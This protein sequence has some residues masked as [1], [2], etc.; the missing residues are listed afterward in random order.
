MCVALVGAARAQVTVGNAIVATGL[1]DGVTTAF[2]LSGQGFGSGAVGSAVSTW[3]FYTGD[4]SGTLAITPLLFEYSGTGFD[5]VLRAIGTTVVNVTAGAHVDLPFD[6]A[7]GSATITS[8]DFY[9]GWKDDGGAV[10]DLVY[11]GT[12]TLAF[13][14]NASPSLVLG[15]TY[16][17]D[18][19]L[20]L[21]TYSISAT[22]GAVP[23]PASWAAL[24]GLVAAIGSAW[25][26]GNR[27]VVF[28][29]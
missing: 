7:S 2:I 3:S 27:R 29:R 6:V 5:Y 20:G 4:P 28:S 10:V 9:L 18:N 24:A 1:R 15:S 22:T 16:A 14:N 23:E 17:F 21:R 12:G 13:H 25:R 26:R 19:D 8:G 11:G